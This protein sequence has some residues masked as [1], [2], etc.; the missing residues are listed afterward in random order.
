[1]MFI[2]LIAYWIIRP[3]LR[4]AAAE[5]RQL[6][7]DQRAAAIALQAKRRAARKIKFT[8]E[9]LDYMR[10]HTVSPYRPG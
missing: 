9:E 1:M 3:F 5:R 7:R 10:R 4:K 6:E 2:V 8:P